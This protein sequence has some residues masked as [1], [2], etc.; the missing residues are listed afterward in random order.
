MYVHQRT[1]V[2]QCFFTTTPS[3]QCG[4]GLRPE[5]S[6]GKGE[7]PGRHGIYRYIVDG[8]RS[9]NVTTIC[10]KTRS[11]SPGPIYAHTGAPT[12]VIYHGIYGSYPAT[13][14]FVFQAELGKDAKRL[15]FTTSDLENLS[16]SYDTV[17]CID[18]MIHYPTEKVSH[19]RPSKGRERG[20][21]SCVV[22]FVFG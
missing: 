9:N 14:P 8:T 21:L 18:V 6:P 19:H 20:G 12:I 22:R 16:G 3:Q 11:P 7:R 15:S 5:Y 13:S 10:M 2:Y 1:A 4:L 17:L